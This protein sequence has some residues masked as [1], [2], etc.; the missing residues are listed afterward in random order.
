M[1]AA[2][3]LAR[4]DAVTPK[5]SGRALEAVLGAD[6]T[7]VNLFFLSQQMLLPIAGVYYSIRPG[8]L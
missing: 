7:F 5:K 1:P 8:R 4:A 6:P 3:Q 2:A